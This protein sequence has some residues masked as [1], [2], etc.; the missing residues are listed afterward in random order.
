MHSTIQWGVCIVAFAG[1]VRGATVRAQQSGLPKDPTL[2]CD[3]ALEPGTLRTPPAAPMR[4]RTQSAQ[5]AIEAANGHGVYFHTGEFHLEVEDLRFPGRGLDLVWARAYRSRVPVESALG[6][7]W[8][9]SYNVHLE[10]A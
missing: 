2:L 3:P 1:L 7:G 4:E 5:L 9:H 6:V 8:D 10:K